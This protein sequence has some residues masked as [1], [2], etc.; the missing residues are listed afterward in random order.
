MLQREHP[1]SGPRR[2]SGFDISDAQ[3]PTT[4]DGHFKYQVQDIL[5]PFSPAEHG[6]YDLVHARLLVTALKEED[7]GRAI[8]NLLP[9]LSKSAGLT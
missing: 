5:Q 6:K 7:Y 4:H 8:S 3:F 1:T 9:L 2:F